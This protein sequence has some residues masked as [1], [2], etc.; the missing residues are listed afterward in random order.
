MS[1]KKGMV[2]IAYASALIAFI[3]IS[4]PAQA[5]SVTF[6]YGGPE[7]SG[8]GVTPAVN[9]F[10]YATIEDVTGGVQFTL[11][12]SSLLNTGAKVDDVYFNYGTSLAPVLA[13]NGATF[14]AG[15]GVQPTSVAV[16]TS[17]GAHNADGAHA[18]DVDVSFS[19]SSPTF[20]GGQTSVFS[21][22]GTGLS[23]LLFAN[24][25]DGGGGAGPF[26]TAIHVL[27]LP[28]STSGN[29]SGFWANCPN[30]GNVP[31]V[32]LPGAV[33]LM[34]TVLIGGGF[35]SWLRRRTPKAA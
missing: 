13:L 2:G 18:F 19:T 4:V 32:P 33:W 23:A 27:A 8:S 25:S 35:G 1:P 12:L 34:G 30:C 11:H 10:G 29:T 22:L 17:D 5:S 3:G 15:T 9:P 31:E 14:A 20:G 28:T 26:Q 7:Y 6:I 21:L 24:L 16:G